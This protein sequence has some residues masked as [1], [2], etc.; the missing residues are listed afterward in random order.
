MRMGRSGLPRHVQERSF[1]RPPGVCLPR[2]RLPSRDSS[3]EGRFPGPA[4]D[5]FKAANAVAYDSDSGKGCSIFAACVCISLRTS[6][7]AEFLG[8]AVVEAFDQ[9]KARER[10]EAAGIHQAGVM[11]IVTQVEAV[12][13]RT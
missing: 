1:C 9:I 12:H 11:S 13:R 2:T 3:S 5:A 7:Q 4:W 10:A 6:P 8:A